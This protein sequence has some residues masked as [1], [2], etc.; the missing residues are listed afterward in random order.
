MPF[1]CIQVMMRKNMLDSSEGFSLWNP[2]PDRFFS[3]YRARRPRLLQLKSLPT[4]A[5]LGRYNSRDLVGLTH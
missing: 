2:Q 5:P 3:R 4:P 1:C